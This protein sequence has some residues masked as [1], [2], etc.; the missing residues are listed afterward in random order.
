MNSKG[1]FNFRCSQ[2]VDGVEQT[3]TDIICLSESNRRGY[4]E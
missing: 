2:A 1:I 4:A 3:E